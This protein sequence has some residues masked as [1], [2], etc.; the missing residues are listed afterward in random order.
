M[1]TLL[2][3]LLSALKVDLNSLLGKIGIKDFK[4]DIYDI[5]ATLKQV[6]AGDKIIPLVNNILG[7][8]KIKGTPLGI[9]LNDV[10]WLQLASHG[11]T[12]IGASQAATFG[13]R[14]Y[15]EGDSSE[16]LIAVLRYLIDTVNTGN[17]FDVISSLIG[18]LLGDNVSDSISDVI[19]NV[20]A[21]LQGDTDEV[22]S[23]LV[24]LLEMLA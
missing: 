3:A 16:T 18:S 15:V 8:I 14:I 7:I 21:V 4:L 6:L 24:E 20:L 1:N 19:G 9:K 22:I 12:I 5:N 17:N 10:D 13:P 11:K 23:K 2:P